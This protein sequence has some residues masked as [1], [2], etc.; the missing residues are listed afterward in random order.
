M[1]LAFLAIFVFITPVNAQQPSIISLGVVM[2]S[3][4]ISSLNYFSPSEN[5]YFTSAL[6]LPFATYN[7]PPLPPLTPILAAGW[8]HNANYTGWV[9]NLKPNLK[10]DNGSPLNASDLYYSFW[11]Y[12]HTNA[13]SYSSVVNNIKILNSTAIEF[14]TTA[15]EPNAVYLWVEETN[16][17]IVPY[18]VYSHLP[19]SASAPG[20]NLYNFTNFQNIVA[21]GPFVIYNYT[22]GENPI[23]FSANPYYYLGPPHMK[24][25]VVHIYSSTSSYLAAYLS[26]QVDAYWA[27]GA[28]E[29]AAALIK[30]VPGHSFYNIVPGGEILATLNLNEYP[31]NITQ[32]REALAYATNVTEI[33]QKM[34]GPYA[35]NMT[36]YYDNLI[37]SLNEQIGLNVSQI[38]SYPYN[39]SMTRALLTSIGFKQSSSGKWLYPNGTP[40]SINIVTTQLGTGD[41]ATTTLLDAMWKSAGFDV[42][43]QTLSNTQYYSL[44]FSK[45]GW[46]VAVAVGPPGYYP[47][48]LGNLIGVFSMAEPYNVSLSAVNGVLNYNYTDIRALLSLAQEY[49]INSPQSN[50]YARKAALEI[51]KTVPLI[52][53]YA[54]SNWQGL[55][56]A[57]YWGNPANYTGIFSTQALV[58]PQLFWN[59]LWLVQPISSISSSTTTTS[60]TTTTTSYTT[61]SMPSST[62]STMTQAPSPRINMTLIAAIVAIMIIIVVMAVLLRRR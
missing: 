43:F 35:A 60:T 40:V 58:Q 15:P 49:P 53:L 27:W 51:A 33:N 44:I 7:F 12:N 59:A 42:N 30:N 2:S 4:I 16:S 21:D 31:F 3:P 62:S 24:Q 55:S 38:P 37:A 22:P 32:F 47:T 9:L 10:W 61:S 41:V 34:M 23:V 25:L 14:N 52:P 48:G 19:L 8:S 57:F 28:Y 39:L 36:V 26:G 11:L 54:I 29:V 18:Q 5:Y 13:I 1:S 17:Y 46:Q 6:Y 20:A 56:N 50:Y 45:T